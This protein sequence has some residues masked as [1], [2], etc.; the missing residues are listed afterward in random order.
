MPG[1]LV[2][3]HDVEW[4]ELLEIPSSPARKGFS[5]KQETVFR[6]KSWNLGYE[7]KAPVPFYAS[8]R[9]EY[10]P[11]THSPYFFREQ[12]KAEGRSLGKVRRLKGRKKRKQKSAP[13]PQLQVTE[14]RSVSPSASLPP[15]VCGSPYA[16]RVGSPIVG[17]EIKFR[18][19]IS[20]DVKVFVQGASGTYVIGRVP[21]YSG[22]S[23]MHLR[24]RITRE[25]G[26]QDFCFV[27]A[28]QFPNGNVHP[29]R[30]GKARPKT[31]MRRSKEP[32][33]MAKETVL[34]SEVFIEER[35]V[36]DRRRAMLE[37]EIH[38]VETAVAVGDFSSAPYLPTLKEELA[39]I[40]VVCLEAQQQPAL[41]RNSAWSETES[42]VKRPSAQLAPLSMTAPPTAAMHDIEAAGGGEDFMGGFEVDMEGGGD[43]ASTPTVG[44]DGGYNGGYDDVSVPSKATEKATTAVTEETASETST[45]SM[46]KDGMTCLE[47]VDFS[48]VIGA[49]SGSN[50]SGMSEELAQKAKELSRSYHQMYEKEVQEYAHSLM[51]QLRGK[52]EQ[53]LVRMQTELR[54]IK[55]GEAGQ[56]GGEAS[57]AVRPRPRKQRSYKEM[58]AKPSLRLEPADGDDNAAAA[59]FLGLT[60]L[61]Q[62]EVGHFPFAGGSDEIAP[63]LVREGGGDDLEIEAEGPADEAQAQAPVLDDAQA[64]VFDGF[65]VEAEE[66]ADQGQAPA[67]RRNSRRVSLQMQ[68]SL[69]RDKRT[70]REREKEARRESRGSGGVGTGEGR[71]GET[72]PV[73]EKAPK[74][75]GRRVSVAMQ[76]SLDRAAKPKQ[77][78]APKAV[79]MPPVAE[80][81]VVADEGLAELRA[82][83]DKLDKDSGGTVDKKEWGRSL[84][85]NKA[86]M[87]K[88][89]GGE[90][91]GEIGK[92]F[93]RIDADASG[94][95]TWEEVKAAAKGGNEDEKSAIKR[96]KTPKEKQIEARIP[97]QDAAST[98]SKDSP[99]PL[100]GAEGV[101]T[102]GLAAESGMQ[103]PPP[104]DH[105]DLK[106]HPGGQTVTSSPKE[107]E[108]I[109]ARIPAQDAASTTSKD[110]NASKPPKQMLSDWKRCLGRS[111]SYAGSLKSVGT[112]VRLSLTGAR[113][114]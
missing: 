56:E 92:Q 111:A 12:K 109:E 36:T 99:T 78:A 102:S 88:H 63:A 26:V 34:A 25:I 23:F 46:I 27:T 21:L 59:G 31:P 8:A 5:K 11:F 66:P 22:D 9:D 81:A 71:G 7:P 110:G 77:D 3:E 45:D 100:N 17:N 113:G 30:D 6:E 93:N 32:S 105:P 19:N 24:S 90:T 2:G 95:L 57:A 13:P 69:E 75:R 65:E 60:P 101:A 68:K 10:C 79:V 98:A 44:Y 49:N 20:Q 74:K 107:G 18:G 96:K 54:P 97:A 15:P 85:Q 80:S 37:Q 16:Q 91:M 86:L 108:Q 41:A 35:S 14:E 103:I 76:R 39:A 114:S 70:Q 73:K 4:S 40:K 58:S 87:A 52:Y 62:M 83:F 104:P 82:L 38:E 89:F 1:G 55:G 51:S 106:I 72:A 47:F 94:D 28:D 112:R 42:A 64:P 84:S 67:T 50:G 48:S 29:S 53:Q 43:N 33:L 61:S